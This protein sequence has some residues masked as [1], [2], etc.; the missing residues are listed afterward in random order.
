[1]V[2]R[3]WSQSP[4]LR[5]L[6]EHNCVVEHTLINTLS[7]QLQGKEQRIF[8][9]V[10]CGKALRLV[11]NMTKSLV[12]RPLCYSKI[13]KNDW[14][15]VTQCS[16]CKDR[17]ILVLYCVWRCLRKYIVFTIQHI[18]VMQRNARHCIICEPTLSLR[19]LVTTE[20][21]TIA[22]STCYTCSINDIH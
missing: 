2:A 16:W 4:L 1:M 5:V 22:T 11:P 13:M 20:Y 17:C 3:V 15:N 21:K 14:S 19:K 6:L 8:W 12:L 7:L 10:C 18:N 9:F